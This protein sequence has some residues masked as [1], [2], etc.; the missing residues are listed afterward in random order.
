MSVAPIDLDDE[1][2]A[3]GVLGPYEEEPCLLTIGRSERPGVDTQLC[4]R[5]G[6]LRETGVAFGR[7]EDEV[8][9][10]GADRG[11][12][13][14]SERAARGRRFE[15]HRRHRRETHEPH[16]EPSGRATEIRPRGEEHRPPSTAMR[17]AGTHGGGPT[18]RSVFNPRK[19]LSF[20][21][22]TDHERERACDQ[23]CQQEVADQSEAPAHC[24]CDEHRRPPRTKKRSASTCQ[25]PSRKSG[26]AATNVM[27]AR[28]I[29][30]GG[31]AMTARIVRK[32]DEMTSWITS[33]ARRARGSSTGPAK[34]RMPLS[35]T[36]LAP[37]RRTARRYCD[38]PAKP[39]TYGCR[40]AREGDAMGLI[41]VRGACPHD[42][43][44]NSAW[45][46]TVDDGVVTGVHGNPDHPITAGHLCIKVQ[47]YEERAYHPD[48]LLTPLVRTGPK[49]SRVVP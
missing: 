15:Q 44:D 7:P 47:K 8:H 31:M 49:G 37:G 20:E 3:V 25:S 35:V 36:A 6:H 33:L 34:R 48:R 2:R 29:V 13:E 38:L 16:G 43:P 41:E 14:G 9:D 18:S 24:G 39:A 17:S 22:A 27:R 23:C 26:E 1:R 32:N 46:A 45:V 28:S 30:V 4:E 42:C 40:R 19:P 21:E 12:Q 10:A 5:G 11:H